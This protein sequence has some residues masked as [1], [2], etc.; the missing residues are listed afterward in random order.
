MVVTMARVET[1]STI[2]L[3]CEGGIRR[4]GSLSMA[5]ALGPSWVQREPGCMG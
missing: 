1:M 4:E 2:C 5:R 3:C